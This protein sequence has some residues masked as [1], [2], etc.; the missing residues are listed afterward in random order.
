MVING[1]EVADGA[2]ED[3]AIDLPNLPVGT[4]QLRVS[5][6]DRQDTAT[7]LVAPDTSYQGR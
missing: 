3:G 6:G 1:H 7:L 5:A 4:Y 2:I